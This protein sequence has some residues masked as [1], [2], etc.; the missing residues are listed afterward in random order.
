MYI[1]R[2]YLQE[3]GKAVG[4]M[5]IEKSDTASTVCVISD[6]FLHNL[7]SNNIFFKRVAYLK[8]YYTNDE[9]LDVIF[10]KSGFYFQCG[11]FNETFGDNIDD[12]KV[13]GKY[14]LLKENS[15]EYTIWEYNRIADDLVEVG[16]LT[17]NETTSEW[18]TR[19]RTFQSMMKKVLDVDED[20]EYLNENNNY[21][22][23][24]KINEL[25][26]E[27]HN[28]IKNGSGGGTGSSNIDSISVNETKITPDKNKNVN[29]KVPTK[30]TDLNDSDDYAKKTD[31]HN[32]DVEAEINKWDTANNITKDIKDT[33][34]KS[35]VDEKFKD[36]STTEDINNKFNDYIKEE[37]VNNKLKDY[38]KS[39]EID[40]KL[41]N[42][43]SD[44]KE[45]ADS[46]ESLGLKTVLFSDNTLK[47]YKKSNAL[48]SDNPDFKINLP[49][50][51][52]LDQTKTTFVN[53]FAWSEESYPNSTN[54]NLDGQPVLILAVK[55]DKS[56]NYSFVSMNEIIKIYKASSVIST[57]KITID[58]STNT[59]SGE[60]NISKDKDNILSVGSD[61]GLFATVSTDNKV[62]KLSSDKIKEKQ[63]LIDDG[64]G[65][66]SGSGKSI[67]DLI[68]TNKDILD[69]ITNEKIEDWDNAKTNSHTH[70]NKDILDN[71]TE[72]NITNWSNSSNNS[73][74]HTNK[75]VIDKFTEDDN[76]NV[77]YNNN[78]LA[79]DNIWHGTKQEYN[80]LTEKSDNK[81]YVVTDEEEDEIDL[82]PLI[83]NDTLNS[84][85]KKTWSI[86]KIINFITNWEDVSLNEEDISNVSVKKLK[87][88]NI[89]ILHAHINGLEYT[90][91]TGQGTVLFSTNDSDL[92]KPNES[93]SNIIRGIVDVDKVA[94][95]PLVRLMSDV[96]YQIKTGKFKLFCSGDSTTELSDVKI[97]GDIFG[98]IYS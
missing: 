35:E 39:N 78:P 60:I 91:S 15:D 71:I 51:Q 83:I 9:K 92:V 55:G 26:E 64:N 10:S 89:V 29:I 17:N 4:G 69:S 28:A 87:L 34:R 3:N 6:S 31:I 33:Y 62:D 45:W 90:G 11:Y 32:V 93:D 59:I 1:V 53:K 65:N 41:T 58:D 20:E 12:L 27:F 67:D 74:T 79:S 94:E 23:N 37:D 21:Y 84:S 22:E 36:Y 77:L 61:G 8:K 73:H 30:V 85:T 80:S 72:E 66:I 44:L 81:T 43:T 42:L 82:S 46:E 95:Q 57:V 7:I 88:G 40:D 38:Y 86:D 52:F 98:I 96:D 18:Y 13:E 5:P 14:Y 47:F 16:A 49:E 48:D 19:T 50:E 76:G 70:Q 68:P 24:K 54:P 97:F 63:I 56:I 75:E 25:M 2:I